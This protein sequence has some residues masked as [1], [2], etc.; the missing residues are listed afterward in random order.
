MIINIAS[1]YPLKDPVV[2]ALKLVIMDGGVSKRHG[3]PLGSV[4]LS[5]DGSVD[6]MLTYGRYID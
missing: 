1:D 3:E 5:D 4:Y 2:V 6:E